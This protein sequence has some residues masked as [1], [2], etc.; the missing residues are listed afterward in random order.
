MPVN[1]SSLSLLFF[2]FFSRSDEATALFASMVVTAQYSEK[3]TNL[4]QVADKLHHI[5]LYMS[6]I[7]TEQ[8]QC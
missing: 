8:F 1:Q 2:S 7:R 3:I 5:M 6:G 4:W